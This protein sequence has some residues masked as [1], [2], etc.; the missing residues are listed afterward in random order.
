[1]YVETIGVLTLPL[2][3]ATARV[4]IAR[5]RCATAPATFR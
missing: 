3:P 5:E 1:M 2:A 4:T